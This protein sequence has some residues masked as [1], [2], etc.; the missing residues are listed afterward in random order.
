VATSTGDD[1]AIAVTFSRAE[2]NL[3][4]RSLAEAL[5]APIPERERAD[6]RAL[7]LKLRSHYPK[8]DPK[9]APV[10]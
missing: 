6:I 4:V 5:Q 1:A 7:V 10:T 2:L 3:M 9:D 8:G